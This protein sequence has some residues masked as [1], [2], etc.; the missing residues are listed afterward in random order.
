[1]HSSVVFFKPSQ[2]YN[3]PLVWRLSQRDWV[4]E[5]QKDIVSPSFSYSCNLLQNIYLFIVHVCGVRGYAHATGSM[6]SP[7]DNMRPGD[8]IH[9]TQLGGRWLFPT[10]PSLWSLGCICFYI[11]QSRSWW[12]GAGSV[13][14]AP[15]LLLREWKRT[16]VG[17]KMPCR[18]LRSPTWLS[19]NVL[20][21]LGPVSPSLAKPVSSQHCFHEFWPR[22]CFAPQY[23]CFLSSFENLPSELTPFFGRGVNSD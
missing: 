5:G 21:L 12:P 16:P 22:A 18:E 15:P 20:F 11:V 4:N 23:P 17:V 7:E 13:S 8:S 3:W 10:E 2:G 1:M 6:Q 14:S 9:G 19:E